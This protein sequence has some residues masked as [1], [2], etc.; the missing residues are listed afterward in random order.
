MY[1]ASESA[2]NK[3]KPP[4]TLTRTQKN[5]E[6]TCSGTDHCLKYPCSLCWRI[7]S[8]SLIQCTSFSFS[9]VSTAVS[10]PMLFLSFTLA[11]SAPLV[12]GLSS[13]VV[14]VLIEASQK[15]TL[16]LSGC[17]KNKT[18]QNSSFCPFSTYRSLTVTLILLRSLLSYPFVTLPAS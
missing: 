11:L 14:G 8:L 18:K 3:K 2:R 9:F 13:Y 10:S 7:V 6:H 17:P 1:A 16:D 4:L 15:S 5:R 12:D